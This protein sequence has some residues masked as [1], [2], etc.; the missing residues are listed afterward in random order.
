MILT[1]GRKDAEAQSFFVFF[2]PS[3][4]CAFALNK[5]NYVDFRKCISQLRSN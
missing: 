5:K 2:N 3:R 4:L 1:Q